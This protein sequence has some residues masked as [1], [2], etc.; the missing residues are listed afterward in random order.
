M[1]LLGCLWQEF[2][3]VNSRDTRGN[4][5]KWST[6]IGRRF[7]VPTLELTESPVHIEHD[8]TVVVF[9]DRSGDLRGQAGYP[10]QEPRGAQ[11][12]AGSQKP[13]ATE[14]MVHRSTGVSCSVTHRS[15]PR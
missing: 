15:T 13:S 2:T 10:T 12:P 7:R 4:R 9:G 5:A 6:G 1:H 8:D 3:D 14:R 11:E